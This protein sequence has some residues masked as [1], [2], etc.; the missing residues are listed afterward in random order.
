MGDALPGRDQPLAASTFQASSETKV[1]EILAKT[2]QL[3]K[4]GKSELYKSTHYFDSTV[5]NL[6][7]LG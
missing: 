5:Q 7:W 2:V 4:D 1:A 3:A 6:N